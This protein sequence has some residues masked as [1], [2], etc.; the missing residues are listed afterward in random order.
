MPI[1]EYLCGR[2]SNKF[3][4]LTSFN[5]KDVRCSKCNSKKTKKLISKFS[6][7]AEGETSL[8]KCSTCSS[9]SCDTCH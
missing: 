3:E 4:I 8:S 1:Y 9:S 5:N 7:K 2:C 6:V